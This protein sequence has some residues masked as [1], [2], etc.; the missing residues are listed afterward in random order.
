MVLGRQDMSL[1][2]YIYQGQP[3]LPEKRISVLMGV[4]IASANQSQLLSMPV[5]RA[6]RGP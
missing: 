3:C 2:G 6:P 4:T 1:A 5:I